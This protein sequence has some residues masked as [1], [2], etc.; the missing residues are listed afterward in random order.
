MTT[1]R[2]RS[3]TTS[4][5]LV[6]AIGARLPALRLLTEAVDREGY[7]DDETPYLHAGLP[8]AVV[9]PTTTADVVELVRIAT[10]LRVPIVPRGAGTG[11]SGGA[12][13]IEDGLTV[14]FTAMDTIITLAPLLGLLGTVT[15]IMASFT[16]IGSSVFYKTTQCT[17]IANHRAA[18]ANIS[19][20]LASSYLKIRKIPASLPL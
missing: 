9:F 3:P 1:S 16:S 8:R 18:R 2:T 13:G 14:V 11:L 7:R 20:I 17:S 4:D 6:A 5:P 12:A 10:E 19:Q 15:G